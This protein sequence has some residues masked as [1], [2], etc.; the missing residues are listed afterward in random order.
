M[1]C[2]RA[3]RRRHAATRRH[4]AG[5]DR[6]QSPTRRSPRG[7]AS[8]H[9]PA[10]QAG[11]RDSDHSA[12][13]DVAAGTDLRTRLPWCTRT[14]LESLEWTDEL[15]DHANLSC[16][17]SNDFNNRIQQLTSSHSPS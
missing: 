7:T 2:H 14:F 15:D 11:A 6:D 1:G 17:Y 10:I 9:V 5:P 4:P 8:T 13:N 16:F 12:A 3:S